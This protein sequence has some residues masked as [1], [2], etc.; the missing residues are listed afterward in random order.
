MKLIKYR[1]L[2]MDTEKFYP[3]GSTLIE[4]VGKSGLHR[5]IPNYTN[6]QVLYA[7]SNKHFEEIDAD[8]G[9]IQ[10][11]RCCRELRPVP[12]RLLD[13]CFN[14]HVRWKQVD[15]GRHWVFGDQGDDRVQ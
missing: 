15:W 3:D 14:R 8:T 1:Y 12:D 7:A 4:S 2:N 5:A 10:P 13:Q 6:S 9:R 11:Q